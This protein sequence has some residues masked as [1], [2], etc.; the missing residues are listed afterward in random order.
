[1]IY[2]LKNVDCNFE[3]FIQLSYKSCLSLN[4]GYGFYLNAN[5]SRKWILILTGHFME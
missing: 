3:T 5:P 1:M 4:K 2:R